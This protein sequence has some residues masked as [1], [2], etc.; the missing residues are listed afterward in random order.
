MHYKG[1]QVW[2]SCDGTP[3]TEYCAKPEGPDGKTI[4]C[5]VPSECGKVRCKHL[6]TRMISRTCHLRVQAF[7]VHWRDDV[8]D[9]HLRFVTM[10]DGRSAGA[11][12]CAPGRS[13]RRWGVRISRTS[14]Q[15]FQFAKLQTTGTHS[16][17]TSPTFH[18]S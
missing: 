1:F 10:I 3:L 6:E 12:R 8:R 2:I 13:G 11:N 14:R 17:T 15:P 9:T 16:T 5:F 18:Q 4:A 7:T